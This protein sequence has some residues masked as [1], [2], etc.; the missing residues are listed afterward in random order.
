ML[1]VALLALTQVSAWTSSSAPVLCTLS[2]RRR[3]SRKELRELCPKSFK[4][5]SGL[6]NGQ[7]ID[8]YNK[9]AKT[10][11]SCTSVRKQIQD[12]RR[13]GHDQVEISGCMENRTQIG[14]SCGHI[15][16]EGCSVEISQCGTAYTF[17]PSDCQPLSA[18]CVG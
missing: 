2:T 12:A 4:C 10:E 14:M 1:V 5:D 8:D 3:Y 13:S 15:M 6:E 17:V 18:S 7:S 9:C 16:P 11:C